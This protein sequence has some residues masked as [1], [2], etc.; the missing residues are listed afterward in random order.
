M[1][2]N[3]PIFTILQSTERRPPLIL[4]EPVA[5]QRIIQEKL[6]P[7]CGNFGK[8]HSCLHSQCQKPC[9]ILEKKKK[10]ST[11]RV[12]DREKSRASGG[13]GAGN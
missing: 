9:K 2:K 4:E 13:N 8:K 1:M 12:E 7:C 11:K 3:Q 5:K 10:M 6:C